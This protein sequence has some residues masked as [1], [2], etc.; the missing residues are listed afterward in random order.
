MFL[1]EINVDLKNYSERDYA[2][3]QAKSS[4][5][6]GSRPIQPKLYHY[7]KLHLIKGNQ[8]HNHDSVLG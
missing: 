6:I 4:N 3:E 2:Y 7:Q 8:E 5:K 1:A